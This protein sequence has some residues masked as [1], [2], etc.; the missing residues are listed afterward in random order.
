MTD[1]RYKIEAGASPY[2]ATADIFE[3]MPGMPKPAIAA[4]KA[5]WAAGMRGDGARKMKIALSLPQALNQAGLYDSVLSLLSADVA[6]K[7]A[8]LV[9]AVHGLGPAGSVATGAPGLPQAVEGIGPLARDVVDIAASTGTGLSASVG[10]LDGLAAMTLYAAATFTTAATGE[11]FFASIA[12]NGT[13]VAALGMDAGKVA[14]LAR[15]ERAGASVKLVTTAAPPLLPS[16]ITLMI[17]AVS[18]KVTVELGEVQIGQI[19][20]PAGAA[21]LAWAAP[22]SLIIGH[23]GGSNVRQGRVSTLL[24][25]AGLDGPAT[26][27]QIRTMMRLSNPQVG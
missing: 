2:G 23:N 17:D 25:R 8:G 6:V 18:G 11:R 19:D 13:T 16:L 20:L 1:V 15:R 5:A 10:G 22:T 9:T 4:R 14:A 27:A 12:A 3:R 21:A 24:L 26:R 7:T